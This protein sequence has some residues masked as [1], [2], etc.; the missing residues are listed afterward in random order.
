MSFAYEGAGE[1]TGKGLVDGVQF[2]RRWLVRP[3]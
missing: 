3:S 1:V 2:P